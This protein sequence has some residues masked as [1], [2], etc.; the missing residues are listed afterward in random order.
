[1]TSGIDTAL[2][3][4]SVRPCDDFYRFANGAW[5][6]T[7]II[8]PE[9]RAWG[10]FAEIRDRNQ[11][12]L[13]EILEAAAGDPKI[14]PGTPRQKVGDLFASGMDEAGI[15]RAGLAPIADDLARIERARTAQDR[16]TLLAGL[17]VQRAFPG[18]LIAVLPDAKDSRS[19]LLQIQQGGLGLP[20]REYYLTDDDRSKELR[21]GYAA[22]V[23][24]M[25]ELLGHPDPARDAATVLRLE[26]RLARA[27]MSRVDQR[28]PDKVYNTQT[29]AE[30]AAHAPGF[31]WPTYLAALGVRETVLNARQPA[32][33][34]ELG[35]MARE[36]SA[37]DWRTYLRWHLLHARAP[38]LPARFED[39]HFAFF[40]RTLQGVPAQQ[41]RWRRVL[42]TVDQR[43]G[44]ALG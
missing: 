26:T 15:E 43:I 29:P 12:V 5:L 35:A 10:A 19:S 3:D 21:D 32:F 17:H 36:E 2:L 28:D 14:E 6:S 13:R 27:S 4:R 30:L 44:E 42:E 22:H 24:R 39:E 11:A 31:E 7:A 38:Y 34:S 16:A 9:E 37:E 41:P 40:Q 8:P 20:D 25:L 1:M 33:L 18:F 23:A